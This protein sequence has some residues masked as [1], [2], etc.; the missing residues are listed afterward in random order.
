MTAG[1]RGQ[2]SAEG[3]AEQAQHGAGWTQRSLRLQVSV[4]E[5]G[6][7]LGPGVF[8]V[9][10]DVLIKGTVQWERSLVARRAL[11]G[12]L[13]LR[14]ALSSVLNWSTKHFSLNKRP[15]R[16][17]HLYGNPV[18]L[19]AVSQGLLQSPAY[20]ALCIS[21][22]S[23]SQFQTSDRGLREADEPGAGADER[24]CQRE[25]C[26]NGRGNCPQASYGSSG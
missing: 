21:M 19:A 26:R 23:I 22:L 20:N 24:F 2:R 8:K 12:Q 1:C 13:S 7:T 14:W 11:E 16:S 9:T 18:G 3:A 4:S 15:P 25:Q 5:S 10:V 17:W 6:F